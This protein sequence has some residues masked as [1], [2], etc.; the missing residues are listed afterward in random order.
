MK[1]KTLVYFF[2]T[3]LLPG[4]LAGCVKESDSEECPPD[5]VTGEGRVL[6]YVD[7]AEALY[8]RSGAL[9]QEVETMF[10]FIFG[11]DGYYI[12]TLVDTSPTI[13]ADYVHE[14]PLSPGDYEFIGW[15]NLH[16]DY[17]LSHADL[18]AGITTVGDLFVELDSANGDTVTGLNDHLHYGLVREPVTVGADTHEYYMELD[19]YT[20]T[21][22]ILTEGLEQNDKDYRYRISDRNGRFGFYSEDVSDRTLDYVT[23]CAKDQNGQLSASLRVLRLFEDHLDATVR[24][25]DTAT[26]EPLYEDLLI[27]KLLSLREQG[28]VVDFSTKYEYTIKLIFSADILMA[29]TIDGWIVYKVDDYEIY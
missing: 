8:T 12:T 28:E 25:E 26:G 15:T 3:A 19:R 9:H 1:I 7:F 13:G 6:L 11:H 2:F 16:G 10:V 17:Y 14:V 29:V 22:D 20:Y 5:E 21:I 27:V 24:I 23:D 18:T 4:F